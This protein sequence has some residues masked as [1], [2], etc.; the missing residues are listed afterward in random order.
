MSQPITRIIATNAE[1]ADCGKAWHAARIIGCD[2][3]FERSRTFHA[4]LALLQVDDRDHCWLLDPLAVSNLEPFHELLA[5]PAVEKVFHSASED[6]QLLGR[7]ADRTPVNIFDTQIAAGLAGVGGS[8]SYQELVRT[9][10]GVEIS[11]SQTRSD[12]LQ[13]PLTEAQVHY[14][15]LDVHYLIDMRHELH[16]RLEALGRADWLRE[17]CERMVRESISDTDPDVLYRRFK[18]AWKQDDLTR[19]AL[20]TLLEWREGHARKCDLPRRHVLDDDT[21]LRLAQQRPTA[22][23]GVTAI[24]Q[25]GRRKA[26]DIADELAQVLA[27]AGATAVA[28]C[29]PAPP[30]PLQ[31]AQRDRL[32]R[33]K[34]LV[35]ARAGELGIE[36]NLLAN[37][38]ELEALVLGADLP[39]RLCGW[40]REIIG[41]Q[42]LEETGR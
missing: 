35:A 15:A 30:A 18:L 29:P 16:R 41:Q 22:P 14:A 11:K 27:R 19:A 20:R 23:A 39:P 31:R 36:P 24:A 7:L 10:C 3:E 17:D 12:W 5:D 33:L 26:D 37:G 8:V 13:R 1:L 4:R 34:D 25:M 6:M 21:V 38:K 28:D 40:R 2:T 9:L 32:R 42:L